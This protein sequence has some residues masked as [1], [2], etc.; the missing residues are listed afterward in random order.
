MK[1]RRLERV[2][3]EREWALEAAAEGARAA[4]ETAEEEKRKRKRATPMGKMKSYQRRAVKIGTQLMSVP[5][6]T[7]V[8]NNIPPFKEEDTASESESTDSTS[9]DGVARSLAYESE[10]EYQGKSGPDPKIVE[11]RGC[12]SDSEGVTMRRAS[13]EQRKQSLRSSGRLNM[14]PVTLDLDG[15]GKVARGDGGEEMRTE[16]ARIRRLETLA[17]HS[18]SERELS[19]GS[20][21]ESE[22]EEEEDEDGDN[23]DDDEEEE[24]EKERRR[25]RKGW[26]RK[27]SRSKHGGEATGAEGEGTGGA[28]AARRRDSSPISLGSSPLSSPASC[29]SP[30]PPHSALDA[31]PG[32]CGK[33]RSA[34][35]CDKERSANTPDSVASASS[36]FTHVLQEESSCDSDDAM[37][38]IRS[39]ST[40]ELHD[41]HVRVASSSFC[42]P[43]P[44]RPITGRPPSMTF[45]S[46]SGHTFCRSSPSR[47]PW[48]GSPRGGP[49]SFDIASYRS[50]HREKTDP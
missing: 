20:D 14:H 2:K 40:P 50:P 41:S 1:E 33:T 32:A 8:A 35:A 38:V 28:G 45:A 22:E 19:R 48:R 12:L 43:S 27:K 42:E 36:G 10:D 3:Q 6:R 49:R 16:V 46:T 34:T 26:R 37:A 44:P 25:A 18:D 13:Q 4:E 30:P 24:E 31:F 39:V 29:S 9:T 15:T 5:S 23:D 7:V 11:L 21:M 47:S 17:T